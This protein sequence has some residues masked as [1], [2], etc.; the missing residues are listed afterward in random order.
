MATARTQPLATVRASLT[1]MQRQGERMVARLRRDAVAL[2]ERSRNEVTK[3]VRDLE[4]RLMRAFHAASTEQVARLE[5]RIVKL[6]RE[7]IELRKPAPRS[8]QAA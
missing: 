1:R 6:E 8:E 4:R 3:D 5:R 7:I 2:V